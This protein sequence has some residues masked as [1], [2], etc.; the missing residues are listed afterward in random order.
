MNKFDRLIVFGIGGS[1]ERV[2]RSLVMLLAG[3]MEM[4]CN[5]IQ[6]VLIDSDEKSKALQKVC[7]LI[8]AYNKM[9][10]LY[11]ITQNYVKDELVKKNSMFHVRIEKPVILNVSGTNVETLKK[12]VDSTN[13]DRD[14]KAEFDILYSE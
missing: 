12:L 5:S 2:M 6:P 3:G 10:E 11:D 9:R 8:T 1:G 4:N 7:D 14:L 13:L